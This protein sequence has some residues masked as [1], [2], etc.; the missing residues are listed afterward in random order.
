MDER[1]YTTSKIK[2]NRGDKEFEFSSAI[3]RKE[4][5]N[6]STMYKLFHPSEL[7]YLENLSYENRKWSYILGRLSAKLAIKSL[8]NVSTLHSI[9]IDSGVFN[10]PVVRCRELKNTQVSITH[11]GSLGISLAY[12]EEHPMGIDVEEICNKNSKAILSQI[13]WN[14]KLLLK[15]VYKNTLSGFTSIWCAKEALSKVLKTGM[16]L[17]FSFLEIDSV[18]IREKTLIY[19]FKNFSQY[20]ALCHTNEAYA[21]AIVLPKNTSVN[22]E[23]FW[24]SFYRH[25]KNETRK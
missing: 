3:V 1:A 12:Q 8:S 15:R 7:K 22:L 4:K 2:M 21:I 9:Y 13:T 17:N 14:E 19:E 24:S 25:R 23:E 10:F 6:T 18:N 20:K 16:M 11:S 5:L